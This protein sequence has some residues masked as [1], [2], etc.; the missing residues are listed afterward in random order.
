MTKT[1]KQ[2]VDS[3]YEAIYGFHMSD[4]SELPTEYVRDKIIDVNVRLVQDHYKSGLSLDGLY[5][6]ICCIEVECVQNSCVIDGVTVLSGTVMWKAEIPNLVQSVGDK[7]IAYLGTDDW[8]NN[9]TRVSMPGFIAGNKFDWTKGTLYTVVGNV[10]YF[11]DLPTTGI[12]LLCMSGILTNPTTACNWNS[13]TSIFPTPD[14]YKLE[15]LVKKDILATFP[16]IGHKNSNDA[17][18]ELGTMPE[19][20]KPNQQQLNG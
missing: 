16:G 6:H 10:I 19:Q 4:D 15:L 5:Q 8:K 3:V 12:K 2:H 20:Q 13:D 17:S 7:N 14:P 11:K 1:L 9:F 18:D